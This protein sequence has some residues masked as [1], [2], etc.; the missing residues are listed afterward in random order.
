MTVTSP[1]EEIEPV[2]ET[3]CDPS[4]AGEV[5][6]AVV[7][8]VAAAEETS[9]AEL[10]PLYEVVDLEALAAFVAHAANSPERGNAVAQFSIGDCMVAVTDGGRVVVRESERSPAGVDSAADEQSGVAD[11]F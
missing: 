1:N 9:P 2:H 5:T 3:V 6:D 4:N 10:D 7:K 11:C 8:A